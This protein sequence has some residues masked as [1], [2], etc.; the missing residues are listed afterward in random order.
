[1]HAC[2]SVLRSLWRLPAPT[3]LRGLRQV[4]LGLVVL[5]GVF[6]VLDVVLNGSDLDWR[7]VSLA[8]L[9]AWL[10][11]LFVRRTHPLVPPLVFAAAV[12]VQTVV[13]A[14]S[15][16]YPTDLDAGVVA[17]VIPFSLTRWARGRDAVLGLGVFLLVAG[18]ALVAQDLSAGDRI[19]GAA[20][21]IAS[22]ALGAA[23][24]SR[25]MLQ[26]RGSS[27]TYASWS[28]S[29]WRATCTTRSP[30]T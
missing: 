14:V 23:F 17:L 5:F 22:T 9:L 15:G 4:E 12:S 27:T 30:T 19:G 10:P 18:S 3:D 25:A 28:G 26:S 6:A 8:T 24:R 2:M 21:V 11:T 20:V 16:T 1:M 29:G 13:G 7:W